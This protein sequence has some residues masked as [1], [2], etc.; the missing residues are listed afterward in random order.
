[1]IKKNRGDLVDLLVK[2]LLL[3]IQDCPRQL[4]LYVC[5]AILG[6]GVLGTNTFWK[7]RF[8]SLVEKGVTNT[9]LISVV[10]SGV[11]MGLFLIFSIALQ[12]ANDIVIMDMERRLTGLMGREVN[13]KANRID[14]VQYEDEETLKKIHMAC[15]GAESASKTVTIILNVVLFQISYFI[16]LANYFFSV[17]PILFFMLLLSFFPYIFGSVARYKIFSDIEKAA[18]P[19]IRMYEHYGECIYGLNYAKETRLLGGVDFFFNKYSQSLET[20]SKIRRVGNCKG[21]LREILMVAFNLIGYV[22]MVIM[23]LYSVFEGGIGIATFAAIFTSLNQIYDDMEYI[24]HWQI[25]NI[26]KCLGESKHYISFLEMPEKRQGDNIPILGDEI[27]L[28]DV[29][30]TYSGNNKPTLDKISLRINKGKTI[31]IVGENGSGKTTLSR[32]LAG[33]C[34]PTSGRVLMNGVDVSKKSPDA[35]YK[36]ISFVFQKYQ[37]YRMTLKENIMI[38]DMDNEDKN[39]QNIL[40]QVELMNEKDSLKSGMDTMLSQEFGGV[41]LSGGQWQRIAIG[42]ALYRFHNFIIL[43]EPTSAI[44]PLE[45]FRLYEKFKSITKEKTAVIITHRIGSARIADEI[46]VMEKGR[47]IDE[48]KYDELINRP[49]K[50]KDMYEAQMKWYVR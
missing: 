6:G 35:V 14:A 4:I 44:D 9:T 33:I 29:S 27:E 5:L 47:I 26:T 45:E 10:K 1:M 18:V 34:L 12:A 46:I 11:V 17:K 36:N 43:D 3:L 22:G 24:F 21:E 37:R 13:R 28:D 16:I 32:L 31:A 42:R 25:G 23:L 40:E 49:G 2:G 8:F 20:A 39:I 15:T 7:D 50:F 48:G 41:D 38:S 19:H 30:F